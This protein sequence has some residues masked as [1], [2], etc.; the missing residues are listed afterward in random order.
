M[1]DDSFAGSLEIGH[2]DKLRPYRS[3]VVR[4]QFVPPFLHFIAAE[5]LAL[6]LGSTRI[7]AMDH[8]SYPMKKL[9]YDSRDYERAKAN[10]CGFYV[11]YFLLS[12]SVIQF[13]IILGLVLFMI[14]G[15]NQSSQQSHLESTQNQSLKFIDE[16][17]KLHINLSNQKKELA[18]CRSK[19]GN[20]TIQLTKIN[21][22]LKSCSIQKIMLNNTI[23]LGRLS[24][25]YVFPDKRPY[26]ILDPCET[27]RANYSKVQRILVDIKAD[28][29]LQQ[30][31]H[32][33]ELIRL[34]S[35]LA[36]LRGNCTSMGR[37]FQ[38]A[39]AETKAKYEADFRQITE[40]IGGHFDPNLS[41]V[42][43]QIRE[44]CTPFSSSFQRQLQEK[45]DHLDTTIKSA[46]RTNHEKSSMIATFEKM[47][48]EC[49]RDLTTQARLFKLKESEMQVFK[50]RCLEEKVL[51][52][53]E[54]NK[55]R[56]QLAAVVRP[57]FRE[58][59]FFRNS[60]LI[61]SP[62]SCRSEMVALT[63]EQAMLM[64]DK[65]MLEGHKA[66][67]QQE[68]E[69]LKKQ[70]SD[71]TTNCYNLIEEQKRLGCRMSG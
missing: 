69:N 25:P 19:S 38:T 14:Y 23:S 66:N 33:L 36:D 48:E 11:K 13:L 37:E 15:N 27:L 24:C 46:W 40:K 62:S 44:N 22:D 59:D 41:K 56:R 60:G 64:N 32:T 17:Y 10:S 26:R 8:N 12:I 30:A 16:I 6:K 71:H 70:L 55:L 52:M 39:M 28:N 3:G 42:L 35:Q 18:F 61:N 7:R 4:D 9:G 54:R 65:R 2:V 63:N 68:L 29:E 5:D 20:L 45:V 58:T 53:E 47:N 34:N 43:E 67:L 51:L 1:P 21:R 57:N 31:R 49:K 50:E